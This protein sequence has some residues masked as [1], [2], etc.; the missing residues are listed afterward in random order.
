MTRG[1]HWFRNDLRID[2]NKA[3]KCLLDKVDEWLPVFVLDPRLEH[4]LERPRY[5]FL[6]SCLEFLQISLESHGVPFLI[7]HGLP[8]E[9]L[10]RLVHETHSS[11]VSF[12]EDITPFAIGRD[13]EVRLL[14]EKSGARVLSCVD[15]V[16][17]SADDIRTQSGGAY[18]KYSPYRK[19]W[20]ERWKQFPQKPCTLNNLSRPISG[21]AM[22]NQSFPEAVTKLPH[23][24]K[25]FLGGTKNAKKRLNVFLER[26]V[27]NYQRDRDV[28]SIDGTSRLS[29]YIR[30]GAISIRECFSKAEECILSEELS[31]IG[32]NKWIDELIWREFYSSIM[33]SNPSV[34]DEN[35]KKEYDAMTWNNSA[36]EFQKWCSG[37]T[38]FP[39][40]DAGIRQLKST[41][42]MH[43]R[44][45]MIV[46]SFLT[47]DLLIH[48]KQ[49][50]RFFS[51]YLL[52]YDPSSNNGGW[53]WAAS[54]GV[55]SQPYFRIFNPEL[56][57]RKWDPQGIFIKRWIPELRDVD[58]EAIHN[59]DRF[60]S[61]TN[62]PR[63]MICHDERR[64]LALQRFSYVRGR[65]NKVGNHRQ[66]QND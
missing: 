48:W 5:K 11:F 28:P 12:N 51:E 38:G 39:I 14:V 61:S 52:D 19:R 17:F 10:P 25:Y 44:V 23:N 13:N 65:K 63:Q 58:D 42:W 29:P 50:E 21:F 57:S 2:D 8:E 45:R 49:G 60:S 7:R 24:S 16:I 47:K 64:K 27:R 32:A 55:D 15:H 59:P 31:Q 37:T 30:F 22:E 9:V 46:A 35:F 40:V 6:A 36:D 66:R 56:Q 3:L 26:L 62:Y 54:T 41:G 20:L 53:Q 1:I 43:N 4:V 33:E 34:L 18:Q